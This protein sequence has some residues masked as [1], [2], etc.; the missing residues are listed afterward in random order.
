MYFSDK[1]FFYFVILIERMFVVCT[2]MHFDIQYSFS[3]L[4]IVLVSA[5]MDKKEKKCSFWIPSMP[6]TV[7]FIKLNWV[8]QMKGHAAAA[9]FLRINLFEF[10]P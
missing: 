1:Y 4:H 6:L 8:C 3:L 9:F 7:T 5:M 10:K 2:N